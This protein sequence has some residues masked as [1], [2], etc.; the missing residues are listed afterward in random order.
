VATANSVTGLPPELLRKGRFDEIFFVDLPNAVEREAI[1]NIHLKR[2]GRDATKFNMKALVGETQGYTGSEIEEIINAAMYEAFYK[3]QKFTGGNDD[4]L[5][6]VNAANATVPL[7]K[8]AP[9]KIEVLRSWAKTRA[10]RAS[11]SEDEVK[12]AASAGAPGKRSISE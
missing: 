2:V 8:T 12:L 1:F 3:K 9:E 7:S 4:T 11:S 6:L 5:L 10:R